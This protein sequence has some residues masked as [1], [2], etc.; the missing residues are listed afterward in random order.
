MAGKKK[1]SKSAKKASQPP[2]QP[3][4]A[5]TLS[6]IDSAI[7]CSSTFMGLPL[8]IR[9]KIYAYLLEPSLV[10]EDPPDGS[11]PSYKFHTAI[12][13]VSQQIHTEAHLQF[14]YG[15]NFVLLHTNWALMSNAAKDHMLP[16][17]STHNLDNFTAHHLQVTLQYPI[18][19]IS[20]ENVKAGTFLHV[21]GDL[22]FLC[23]LLRMQHLTTP[24]DAP[25]LAT[26]PSANGGHAMG[27]LTRSGGVAK[28]KGLTIRL[29]LRATTYGTPN[30]ATQK[31]LLDPFKR[32]R[33]GQQRR[34]RVARYQ[35]E[36]ASEMLPRGPTWLRREAWDM[37]ELAATIKEAGDAAMMKG[38]QGLKHAMDRYSKYYEFLTGCSEVTPQL[39]TM[40]DLDGHQRALDTLCFDTASNMALACLKLADFK[41][42]EH[43][44]SKELV[45]LRDRKY[46]RRP[47]IGK[48][49][50]YLGLAR[51]GLGKYELA[52]MMFPKALAMLG[53]DMEMKLKIGFTE[54]LIKE[55]K[56]SKPAIQDLCLR[57]TTDDLPNTGLDNRGASDFRGLA[58]MVADL[59]A[60]IRRENGIR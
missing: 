48:L 58:N 45:E 54:M 20:R 30:L 27:L 34:L 22:P 23:G 41:D 56:G 3:L 4:A 24:S 2:K 5:S 13:R 15:N 11:T 49:M 36:I 35:N 47:L 28:D 10:I 50:Y 18:I 16:I 52:L 53:N 57:A 6:P 37:F 51:A 31:G 33:G 25:M 32:V 8:D 60:K 19:A 21:A 26:L 7:G 12:L 46:L 1:K 38:P 17:V 14:Y 40:V 59:S 42:A 29:H 43:H 39:D 44:A 9:K 55:R